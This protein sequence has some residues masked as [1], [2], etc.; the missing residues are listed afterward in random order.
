MGVDKIGTYFFL[1]CKK[2]QRKK[3]SPA[4]SAAEAR[5]SHVGFFAARN[6]DSIRRFYQ[7]LTS[8]WMF[9]TYAK[10]RQSHFFWIIKLSAAVSLASSFISS[11]RDYWM[12]VL[13]NTIFY[14]PFFR[15]FCTT[16]LSPAE[17]LNRW[18]INSPTHLLTHWRY[19]DLPLWRVKAKWCYS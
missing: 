10:S 18:I 15:R 13:S 1:V 5:D 4:M 17:S 11:A 3:P 7:G 6:W 14:Q 12:S 9:T 2:S 8:P 19:S 16:L